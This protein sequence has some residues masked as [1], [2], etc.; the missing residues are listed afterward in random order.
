MI[1]IYLALPPDLYGFLVKDGSQTINIK[2]HHRVYS[3]ARANVLVPEKPFRESVSPKN[4]LELK[5]Q[6]G[7]KNLLIVDC[8]KGEKADPVIQISDHRNLVGWNPLEGRTPTREFPQF[9]DMSDIY[10]GDLP[11]IQTATVSTVGAERFSTV[12]GEAISELAA[13][14]ALCA[15]YV[16]IEVCALGWN[17]EKDFEGEALNRIIKTATCGD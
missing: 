13:P 12:K 16:G 15:A 11:G 17:Q 9:P 3:T 7:I 1:F 4:F 2:T 14:I 10:T 8:V 6:L 5:E